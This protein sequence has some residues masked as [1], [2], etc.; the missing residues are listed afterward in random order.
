[1]AVEVIVPQ[2]E[3][4]P[5]MACGRATYPVGPSLGIEQHESISERAAR[6]PIPVERVFTVGDRRPF[7]Q[8]RLFRLC[9]S[10]GSLNITG[11]L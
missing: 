3:I 1:M 5:D 10:I 7:L 8:K 2:P 4:V 6:P 11:I 9:T